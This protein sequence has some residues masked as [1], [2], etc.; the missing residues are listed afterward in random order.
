MR[1]G[2]LRRAAIFALIVGAG[3]TPFNQRRRL[4]LAGSVR[5]VYPPIGYHRRAGYRRQELW[6]WLWVEALDRTI[7]SSTTN[8]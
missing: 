6:V 5:Q 8:S 1:S 7:Y 4:K 3:L 2:I